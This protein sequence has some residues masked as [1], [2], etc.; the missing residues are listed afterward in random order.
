MKKRVILILLVLVTVFS[1]SVTL[2]C[3]SPSSSLA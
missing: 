2:L 1:V 3:Y